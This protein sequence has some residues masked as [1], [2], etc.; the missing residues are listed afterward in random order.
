M[1][2]GIHI[3]EDFY[4][5]DKEKSKY[6]EDMIP[7]FE[8]TVKYANFV[9]ISSDYYQFRPFGCSGVILIAESHFS[10]HTW[11]EHELVTLGIYTCGDP[12][13]AYHALDYLEKALK[14]KKISHFI[15]ERGVDVQEN[16]KI[17][18]TKVVV[19]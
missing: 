1:A 6:V 15:I 19:F 2:V 10:F 8:N 3:I 4:G 18:E 7:I 14:P 12:K 11:P 5:V 13:Q 16:E 9:K 17:E